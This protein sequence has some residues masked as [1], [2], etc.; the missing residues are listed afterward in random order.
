MVPRSGRDDWHERPGLA[1]GPYLLA[2]ETAAASAAFTHR[3]RQ[4]TEF[5]SRMLDAKAYQ[6]GVKLELHPL[7]A[8]SG[9]RVHQKLQREI[10]R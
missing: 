4:H 6:H 2:S 7:G 10:A 5:C 8:A 3:R 1:A 9:D